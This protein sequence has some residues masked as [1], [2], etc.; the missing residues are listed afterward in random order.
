[1]NGSLFGLLL[2]AG[3]NCVDR[4]F[5]CDKYLEASCH[6]KT[7]YSTSIIIATKQP[8]TY[9]QPPPSLLS[10]PPLHPI[11]RPSFYYRFHPATVVYAV[12]ISIKGCLYSHCH[13]RYQT[14]NRSID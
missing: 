6:L 3:L 9:R 11:R 1:M 14:I 4:S 13:F 10:P 5:T 8:P 2:S 7:L 12:G